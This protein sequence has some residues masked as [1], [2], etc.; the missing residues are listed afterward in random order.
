MRSNRN[1][2][3]VHI[4]Y[5]MYTTTPMN[6]D[7]ETPDYYHQA[8]EH[9][10]ET[11]YEKRDWWAPGALV[12]FLSSIACLCTTV[13]EADL[14]YEMWELRS[15]VALAYLVLTY[16]E[17]QTTQAFISLN[18]QIRKYDLPR[19]IETHA[20]INDEVTQEAILKLAKFEI[21]LFVVSLLYPP[22]GLG[23]ITTKFTGVL[24]NRYLKERYELALELAI[25]DHE[26]FQR[27]E[28]AYEDDENW[29]MTGNSDEPYS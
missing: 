25:A 10:P 13:S 3:L 14:G 6:R 16:L 5:A 29:E 24:N 2:P 23:L 8:L 22:L 11:W 12:F 28:T 4:R 19:A 21:G 18:D 15:A 9:L 17:K 27:A 7:V 1:R 20:L 26:Q